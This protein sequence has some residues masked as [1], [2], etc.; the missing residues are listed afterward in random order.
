[1]GEGIPA[2]LASKEYINLS[3]LR[4]HL[5]SNLQSSQIKPKAQV[6]TRSLKLSSNESVQYIDEWP[7]KQSEAYEPNLSKV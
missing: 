3:Y 7:Y 5:T 4:F 1:M 2:T 6:P